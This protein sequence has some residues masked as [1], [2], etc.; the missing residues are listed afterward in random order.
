[1][2]AEIGRFAA[3]VE[4]IGSFYRA[5][6]R[7]Y[8]REY[9]VSVSVYG[10]G[11][12]FQHC[13]RRYIGY[14]ELS[15]HFAAVGIQADRPYIKSDRRI[16]RGKNFSYLYVRFVRDGLDLNVKVIYLR[17]AVG[18]RVISTFDCRGLYCQQKFSGVV[19]CRF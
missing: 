14:D 17:F 7:E 4:R 13:A 18:D 10:A 15:R 12:E 11:I 6:V 3:Y 9:L 19:I 8:G 1:M 5:V 2:F 16:F